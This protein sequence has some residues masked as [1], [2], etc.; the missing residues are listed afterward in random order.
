MD[1]T[2]DLMRT[3]KEQTAIFT[4]KSSFQKRRRQLK[5]DIVNNKEHHLGYRS[6]SLWCC[7]HRCSQPALHLLDVFG[8]TFVAATWPP[9]NWR[10]DQNGDFVNSYF[11][12]WVNSWTEMCFLI[13]TS[14]EIIFHQKIKGLMEEV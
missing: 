5:L 6:T 7:R 3:A 11:H 2:T 1:I 12:N 13:L 14:L 10:F 8:A 4:E 9:G